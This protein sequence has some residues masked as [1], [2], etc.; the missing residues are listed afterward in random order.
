MSAKRPQM[1][2]A[3]RASAIL[4]QVLG[5]N[6][7]DE[8]LSRYQVWMIWDQV[9]GKQIANRARPLRFRQGILEVQVDHP[10]W[11]Q[12]LQMLKPQI[13]AKLHAQLPKADITD[14][15]LRKVPT[16]YTCPKEETKPNGSTWQQMKLSEEEKREIAGQLEPLQDAELREEMLKVALMQKRLNKGRK[17]QD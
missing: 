15:Y 12:Q 7:I 4:K 8:R 10:V 17:E 1:K 3:E 9:V 16:P 2:K 14:I 11:M 5:D 6:G 13:L